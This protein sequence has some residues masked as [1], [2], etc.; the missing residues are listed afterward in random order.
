MFPRRLHLLCRGVTYE[1]DTSEALGYAL[2]AEVTSTHEIGESSAAAR[3]TPSEL[4]AAMSRL[5]QDV[6]WCRNSHKSITRRMSDRQSEVAGLRR[7]VQDDRRVV[8]EM[9]MEL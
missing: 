5:R 2:E 6:E 9:Y 8:G 3:V 4:R 7:E 1:S